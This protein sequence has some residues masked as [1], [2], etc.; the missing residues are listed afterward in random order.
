[1]FETKIPRIG[2]V[3]EDHTASNPN[4]LR[5]RKGEAITPVEREDDFPGWV[6]CTAGGRESWTPVSCLQQQG[7]GFIAAYDYDATELTVTKGERLTVIGEESGWLLATDDKGLTGWV[8]VEI[9]R[10]MDKGT[11]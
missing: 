2:M 3:I 11:A 10:W 1:M 8:P 6:W 4:P 7:D 9:V 5:V